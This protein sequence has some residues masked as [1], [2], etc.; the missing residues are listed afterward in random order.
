MSASGPGPNAT[1]GGADYMILATR[2]LNQGATAADTQRIRAAPGGTADTATVADVVAAD[3]VVADVVGRPC[4]LA[5]Y[6]QDADKNH[7]NTG[8]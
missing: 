1:G 7:G 2:A 8:N 3:V 6:A 5:G 4:S